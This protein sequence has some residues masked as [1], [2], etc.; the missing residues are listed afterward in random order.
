[1]QLLAVK[2]VKGQVRSANNNRQRVRITS[3]GGGGSSAI[4]RKNNNYNTILGSGHSGVKVCVRAIP[5]FN[6]PP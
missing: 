3:A 4:S 2:E 1:M 6:A 5:D